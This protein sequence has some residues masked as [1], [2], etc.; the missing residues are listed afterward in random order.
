MPA[1]QAVG[2]LDLWELAASLPA[3]MGQFRGQGHRTIPLRGPSKNDPERVVWYED[4]A[5]WP[6]ARA[7]NDELMGA[8]D[9]LGASLSRL[10]IEMLDPGALWRHA[11]PDALAA[12]A[13]RTNPAAHWYCRGEVAAPQAGYLVGIVDWYGAANYGDTPFIWL[14]LIWRLGVP[15]AGGEAV[16]L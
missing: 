14:S 1:F 11:R 10:S 3:R 2:W 13:I 6:E 8:A 9:K 16:G 5:K 4:A 7:L 12:V 15:H